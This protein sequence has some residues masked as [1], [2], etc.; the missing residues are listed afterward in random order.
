MVA[1]RW[2]D[3]VKL[4]VKNLQSWRWRIDS[5]ESKLIPK[6]SILSYGNQLSHYQC[7]NASLRSFVRS[8]DMKLRISEPGRFSQHAF[9]P[10]GRAFTL[11][12]SSW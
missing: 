7:N 12:N 3:S 10:S 9:S 11:I 8:R 2:T 1:I 6:G 4:C 5:I